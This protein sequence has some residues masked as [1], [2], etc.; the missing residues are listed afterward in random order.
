MNSILFQNFLPNKFL[1]YRMDNFSP[2]GNSQLRCFLVFPGPSD[3]NF[4][5]I[6]LKLHKY[7]AILLGLLIFFPLIYSRYKFDAI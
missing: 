5:T 4:Y 1:M 7:E 2:E 3:D 6:C